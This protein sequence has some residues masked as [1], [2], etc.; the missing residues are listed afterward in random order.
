VALSGPVK[1]PDAHA[2]VLE[3]TDDFVTASI[4]LILEQAHSLDLWTFARTMATG[5]FIVDRARRRL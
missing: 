3:R 1:V 5:M 4:S 2:A